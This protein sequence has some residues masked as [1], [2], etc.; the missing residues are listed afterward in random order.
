MGLAYTTG[1][2]HAAHRTEPNQTKPNTQPYVVEQDVLEQVV[3]RLLSKRLLV[4]LLLHQLPAESQVLLH[5]GVGDD[6]SGLAPLGQPGGSQRP[7]ADFLP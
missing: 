2:T 3:Q 6:G 7:P 5:G 4:L 1:E